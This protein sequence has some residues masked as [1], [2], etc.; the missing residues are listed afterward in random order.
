M[1]PNR[2]GRLLPAYGI[3]SVTVLAIWHSLLSPTLNL[4]AMKREKTQK[5]KLWEESTGHCIYCGRPVSLE[6]MEI[7]HI[8]PLSA[9]GENCYDNK[10]CSCPAC[11]ANKGSTLLAEFLTEHFSE[12]KLRKYKHRLDTLTEQ[13]KMSIKKALALYPDILLDDD[14][15]EDNPDWDPRG[16]AAF[17]SLPYGSLGLT[18]CQ[19]LIALA[20]ILIGMRPEIH[21]HY[22]R[23]EEKEYGTYHRWQE[24]GGPGG[25]SGR[26]ERTVG[27]S[28]SRL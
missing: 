19:P 27:G 3:G 16:Q 7:D 13:G 23:K 22:G 28:K 5:E 25:S 24:A 10:V 15:Y 18:D 21:I 4:K 17:P 6:D 11:N 8:V 20:G 2:A 14:D 1:G 12:I 26:H 9:G